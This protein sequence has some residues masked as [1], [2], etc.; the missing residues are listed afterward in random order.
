MKQKND[1]DRAEWAAYMRGYFKGNLRYRSYCTWSKIRSRCEDRKSKNYKTY[2]GRGITLCNEWHD[3]EVFWN[4]VQSSNFEVGLQIDRID[5]DGPYCP[6][7]CRWVS[8]KNNNRNRSNNKLD[9]KMVADIRAELAKG[10]RGTAL[11]MAEKYGV[12]HS[13]IYRIKLNKQWLE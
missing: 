6:E 4:W 1:Q 11:R 9:V 7:N 2:G 12:H 5:N 8:S 13:L 10:V 3:F